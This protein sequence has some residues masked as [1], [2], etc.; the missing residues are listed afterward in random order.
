[1]K[2]IMETVDGE[3]P[4]GFENC[5]DVL[6]VEVLG[7]A[8]Y[9]EKIKQTLEH[10]ISKGVASDK[11]MQ[12]SLHELIA[13]SKFDYDAALDCEKR[14]FLKRFKLIRK[15]ILPFDK[16]VAV[17]YD[18][19]EGRGV[20]L[21][22]AIEAKF[23]INGIDYEFY[24]SLHEMHGYEMASTLELD[25]YTSLIIVGG[26]HFINE[27]IN[28]MLQRADKKKIP[29]GLIPNSANTDI[30]KQFGKM[31][32]D[33]ALDYIIQRESIAVDTVRVLIDKESIKG[34]P[35]GIERYGYCRHMISNSSLSMP[36]KIFDSARS[37]Q[38]LCGGASVSIASLIKG[39]TWSWVPERFE[40]FVD[41]NKVKP[42]QSDTE[43]DDSINTGLIVVSN[44]KY[45]GG[46]AI[47]NPHAAVNDGLV[48]ITWVSD[49]TVTGYFGLG[50][51]MS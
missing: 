7:D 48:D 10:M 47:I 49:P 19:S 15:K 17:V 39:I 29:V 16:P 1:M 21:M 23:E 11:F 42:P 20:L 27:V 4:L 6:P 5:P 3:T 2:A 45:Y 36:A 32:L 18:P 12:K 37:Y 33:H 41:G 25:N 8:A 46:G 30:C 40:I 9:N 38:G 14:R 13:I 43:Q 51:V 22:K 24:E 35:P 34:L 26:D 44:G 31:S 50:N 28:G